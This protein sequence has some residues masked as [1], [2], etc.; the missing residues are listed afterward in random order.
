MGQSLAALLDNALRFTPH[1]THLHLDQ[2]LKYIAEVRPRRA[3]LTHMCHDIKHEEAS[4]L[5]P[6]DVEFAYDEL[7]IGL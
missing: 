5:L 3:L 1:P 2:S 6:P 4:R 7:E